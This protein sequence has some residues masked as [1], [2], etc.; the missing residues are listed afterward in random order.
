MPDNIALRI[1]RRRDWTIFSLSTACVVGLALLFHLTPEPANLRDEIRLSLHAPWLYEEHGIYESAS[2]VLLLASV[3]VALAFLR[4][5]RSTHSRITLLWLATLALLAAMRELDMHIYFNPEYLDAMG[6]RYRI[7]WW[8]DGGIPLYLKLSWAAIFAAVGIWLALPLIVYRKQTLIFLRQFRDP[9]LQ[10]LM[11]TGILWA[12]GFKIDDLFREVNL[13][14]DPVADTI[15][16][17]AECLGALTLFLATVGYATVPISARYDPPPAT[18]RPAPDPGSPPA[19]TAP[20]P[21][22]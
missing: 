10:M 16:E 19:P 11:L 6:V 4:E 20:T 14:S 17:G 12:I 2:V 3:V 21:A 8:L 7:D 15:E 9:S 22:A 13:F 5:T 1:L 18:N